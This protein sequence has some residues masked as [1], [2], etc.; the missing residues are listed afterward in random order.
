MTGASPAA[1]SRALGERRAS[2]QA[3]VVQ[4]ADWRPVVAAAGVTWAVSRLACAVITYLAV[5]IPAAAP[6]GPRALLLAWN[7]W[8]TGWYL[9]I[10]QQGYRSRM[11]S[12]FYPLYPGLI[13]GV[14]WL[15]GD[16][17][18]PQW[19]AYDPVRL[20]AALGIA[21]LGTLAG[22]IALALLAWTEERSAAAATWAVRA[23]IVYPFSFMLAAAYS[24]GLFLAEAACCLLLARR[25]RWLPCA[26]AALLAGATRPTAVVLV[27][28]LAWEYFRQHR[29]SPALAGGWRT[30]VPVLLRGA[31][32]VGA[33]PAAIAGYMAY[34]WWRFGDP[35]TGLRVE[36]EVWG[37][38]LTPPWVT[39]WAVGR[40]L[41]FGPHWN[42][43]EAKVLITVL[44]VVAMLAV[45]LLGLRTAP[46]AFTLYMLGLLLLCVASPALSYYNALGSAGRFLV[47][48]VPAFL[49]VGSWVARRPGREFPGFG[50]LLA[51]QTLLAAAYLSGADGIA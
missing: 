48:S 40:D 11:A 13:G 44:A 47:V 3:G 26:A 18:G 8:D 33:A 23:A 43:V 27:A 49:L 20:V 14:S 39:A 19:P 15:L 50:L 29:S 41:L 7:R 46:F 22:L 51:V 24:E 31:A 25:G 16:G 36:S 38:H 21:N 32:A 28:P 34:L 42:H 4:R 35:L 2:A 9:I 10:S 45:T 17:H 1:T 6:T 12:A 5:T 37:R 30:A